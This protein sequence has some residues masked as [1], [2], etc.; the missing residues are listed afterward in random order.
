MDLD[1]LRSFVA[2]AEHQTF[3]AAGHAVSRTQS[4]ISQQIK[5]LEDDVGTQLLIRSSKSVTFTPAGS[6]LLNYARRLLALEEEGRA[7]ARGEQ[8]RRALRIGLTDDVAA[9]ALAPALRAFEQQDASV[10]VSLETLATRDL[11]AG[12]GTRFDIAFAVLPAGSKTGRKVAALPL[13]WLGHARLAATLPLPLAIYPEGCAMRRA[14]VSALD[15]AG[16]AWMTKATVNGLLVIEAAVRAGIAAAPALAGL[17]AP[18]LPQLGGMPKLPKL[19]VRMI[20]AAQ[21]EG[22]QAEKLLKELQGVIQ[23][24][25]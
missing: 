14:A 20:T 12:V 16:R 1:L 10:T 6:T 11:I 8:I 2:L 17:H 13:V 23:N 21:A 9:Y 18:D 5:R 15:K 24:A 7:A 4:A 19:E 3:S 25:G 22:D